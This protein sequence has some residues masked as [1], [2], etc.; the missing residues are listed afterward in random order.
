L[1]QQR[2]HDEAKKERETEHGPVELPGGG[3][4]HNSPITK[5]EQ[6]KPARPTRHKLPIGKYKRAEQEAGVTKS[7][8]AGD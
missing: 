4:D 2:N 5:H 7:A 8:Q 6:G 1:E 3:D